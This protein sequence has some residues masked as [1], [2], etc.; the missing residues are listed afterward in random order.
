MTRLAWLASRLSDKRIERETSCH[1]ESLA[2]EPARASEHL[3][4]EMLR[5]LRNEPGELLIR[6]FRGRLPINRIALKQ[7]CPVHVACASGGN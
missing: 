5:K 1:L 7:V 3:A 2:H 4:R 6:R